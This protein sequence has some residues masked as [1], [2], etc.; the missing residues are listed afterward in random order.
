MRDKYVH[1]ADVYNIN[2]WKVII[3]TVTNA[4]FLFECVDFCLLVMIDILCL[5]NADVWANE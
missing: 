5:V 1:Y 2:S 4:Q 3:R